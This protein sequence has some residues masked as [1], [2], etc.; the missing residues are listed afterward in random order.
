MI[1][2]LRAKA[3]ASLFATYNMNKINGEQDVISYSMHRISHS[4]GVPEPGTS[5]LR[6]L[7]IS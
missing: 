6:M 5:H 1:L 7:C 3:K 2:H 4:V